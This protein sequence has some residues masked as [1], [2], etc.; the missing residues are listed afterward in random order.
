VIQ[1]RHTAFYRV[2]HFRAIPECGQDYMGQVRDESSILKLN[3]RSP[4]F[5]LFGVVPLLL[6]PR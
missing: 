4:A 5:D 1:E 6:S 2:R 3:D